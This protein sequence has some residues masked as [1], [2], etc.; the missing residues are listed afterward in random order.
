M[1]QMWWWMWKEMGVMEEIRWWTLGDG[2]WALSLG[3]LRAGSL[4]VADIERLPCGCWRLTMPWISSR[5]G[6]LKELARSAVA[7]A[8]KLDMAG[9]TLA[10]EA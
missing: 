4:K 7:T 2:H 10:S 8:A 1:G 3:S 5:F 6:E 9:D